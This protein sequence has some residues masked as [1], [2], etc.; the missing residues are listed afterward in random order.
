MT[1]L[2]DEEINVLVK[3]AAQ[4]SA[5]KRDGSTSQRIARAI[6]KAVLEKLKQ[7]EPVAQF[8]KVGCSDWYDGYPDNEDRGGPY[9]TRSIYAAPAVVPDALV[10]IPS[11]TWNESIEKLEREKDYVKGWNDCREAMLS[12]APAATAVPG[13]VEKA[14]KRFNW[15]LND[16]DSDIGICHLG[17]GWDDARY[18]QKEE[19]LELIDAAMQKGTEG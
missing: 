16:Q 11:L 1:I 4:G 10:V 14:A 2:T 18:L 17:T 7:Q 12:A 8:R 5:I 15:L 13:D 9:E 3:E 6:E 19:A